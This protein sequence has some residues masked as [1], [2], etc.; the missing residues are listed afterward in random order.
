MNRILAGKTLVITGGTQGLGRGVAQHCA[1]EGAARI[2]ITG[3]SE[4]RGL[5]ARAEVEKLGASC[6]FVPGD[7]RYDEDC[8][9]IVREAEKHFGV[10]DGLMNAAGLAT[11]GGLEDTSVEKWDLLMNVNARAPFILS[12][13]VVRVM[14]MNGTSGRIVNMISDNAHGGQSFLTAYAASKGALATLTKNMAH[15]LR[16]DR[17]RVNGI[18]LGWMYTP[19]EHQTQLNDGQP[20]NW[21]E[22]AE[23]QKPFGRLLRPQDIAYLTAYLLS[24]QSEMMTGALIDFDQKIIGCYP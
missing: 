1:R 21:L 17:I 19:T 14:K 7:L 15:T 23:Q 16:W 10:I 5:E 4:Q 12:Q 11:R 20:E 8:R 3:R 2:L 24:D 22:K 6:L 9:H 13:E 18:N